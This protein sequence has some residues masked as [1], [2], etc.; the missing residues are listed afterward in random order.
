MAKTRQEILAEEDDLLISKV[1]KW[2]KFRLW[3]KVRISEEDWEQ[4]WE[5]YINWYKIE[6]WF[7]FELREDFKLKKKAVQLDDWITIEWGNKFEFQEEDQIVVE[8][9]DWHTP[10]GSDHREAKNIQFIVKRWVNNVKWSDGEDLRFTFSAQNFIDIFEP[11]ADISAIGLDR[12][13]FRRDDIIEI[14]NVGSYIMKWENGWEGNEVPQFTCQILRDWVYR[15]D[16]TGTPISFDIN[17]GIFMVRFRAISDV[18]DV[19]DITKDST[20]EVLKW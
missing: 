11:V 6:Q 13:K 14:M 20:D 4:P 2:M 10:D 18:D 15:T 3:K 12:F 16:D 1:E 19:I 5:I 17:A 7:R 9:A 8:F